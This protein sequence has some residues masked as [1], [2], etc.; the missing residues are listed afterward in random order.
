MN[1]GYEEKLQE[2]SKEKLRNFVEGSDESHNLIGVILN[3]LELIIQEEQSLSQQISTLR[4]KRKKYKEKEAK[5]L[6][7]EEILREMRSEYNGLLSV[8][9]LIR[10]KLTFEFFADEG[11]LPNYA[12]PE[13]GVLLK[14]V[15]YRKRETQADDNGKKYD[16]YTYE[17]ER[18]GSSAISELAPNNSF[19]AGGRKV[20]ID[21]IDMSLSEVEEWIFCDKCSYMQR[22]GSD[23]PTNCPKCASE[24]FG[25]EGQKKEILRMKQVMATSDDKSSRLKDDKD[26]RDVLFFNKQ[27]LINFDK[28]DIEDAYAIVSDETSFGF[29]FIEKVNFREINFGEV[30]LIGNDISTYPKL[31]SK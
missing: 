19:Y 12:F 11:L 2:N 27:L 18:T 22:Q 14:S 13:S 24:M 28:K 8:R 1:V 7:H 20:K 15:I 16:I 5:E 9:R 3:R 29:E 26:Q 6:N 30:T 31:N 17:Y 4:K 10:G 21:Q 25:D 23:N